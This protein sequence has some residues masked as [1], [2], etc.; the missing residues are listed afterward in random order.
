MPRDLWNVHPNNRTD[1][2]KRLI[3]HSW[4]VTKDPEGMCKWE[5]ATEEDIKASKDMAT[6]YL[7]DNKLLRYQSDEE[8]VVTKGFKALGKILGG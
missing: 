7:R 3:D 8:S 6:K 1:K 4:K 2:E 5:G